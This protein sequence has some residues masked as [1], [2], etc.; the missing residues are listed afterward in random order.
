MCIAVPLEVVAIRDNIARVIIGNTEKEVYLDLLDDVKVRDF[1]L[2]HA[3]FAIEKLDKQEAE[4]TLSLF[5]EIADEIS[6]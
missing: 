1:V 6:R 3:G 4:K 2:V 5:K